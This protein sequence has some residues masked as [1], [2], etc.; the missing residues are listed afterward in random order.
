VRERLGLVTLEQLLLGKPGNMTD[1]ALETMTAAQIFELVGS[2]TSAI[3]AAVVDAVHP[4]GVG[5]GGGA[6]GEGPG[7][8]ATSP[9]RRQTEVGGA[10]TSRGKFRQT[11]RD[12]IGPPE[13][14]RS[15]RGDFQPA[16]D[17]GM[18]ASGL[19]YM[20]WLLRAFVC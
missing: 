6:E 10:E 15:W 9:L 20:V 2:L 14:G 8:K 17:A 18:A 1:A 5:G 11:L 7:R 3:A 13:E 4:D 16:M 12:V 19:A